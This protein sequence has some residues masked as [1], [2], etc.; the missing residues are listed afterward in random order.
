M[1]VVAPQYSVLRFSGLSQRRVF[2]YLTRQRA[3]HGGR[4]VAGVLLGLFTGI[5]IPATDAIQFFEV[6][7]ITIALVES[8]FDLPRIFWAQPQ[9]PEG[10]CG[11]RSRVPT[12]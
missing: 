9:F 10:T 7:G 1:N 5:S 8:V 2:P 3:R 11:W 6:A 4:V 12:R